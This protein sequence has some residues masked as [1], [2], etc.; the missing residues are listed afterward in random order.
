MNGPELD[1]HRFLC[2][3]GIGLGL[4]FYYGFLRP[5]RPRH[6]RLSDLLFF[7]ALFYG[8]L[9]LGFAVCRGD[10]RMGYT[11]GLLVGVLFWEMT[12]GRWL[13]PVFVWFWRLISRIWRLILWPF[14]KIF[15]FFC[16]KLKKLFA[17]WK[18]WFTIIW[19]NRRNRRRGNG[20]APDGEQTS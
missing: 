17:I 12:V 18:K 13:R 4:G 19:T 7:P 15:K 5:L 16:K 9:Y 1:L 20:G 11:A 6:T 2:A 14:E 3:C 8:W 10:I